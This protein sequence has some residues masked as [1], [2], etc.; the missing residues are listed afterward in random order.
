LPGDF[1]SPFRA[2]LPQPGE[3][4]NLSSK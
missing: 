4:R 1:W 2:R 3:A